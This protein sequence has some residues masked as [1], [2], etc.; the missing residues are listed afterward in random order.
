[1]KFSSTV[2]STLALLSFGTSTTTNAADVNQGALDAAISC[3][4]EFGPLTFVLLEDEAVNAA[5]E[6]DIRQDLA[7]IGF[8]VEARPLSKAD[9]NVAKQSGNFHFSISETWGTPYDPSSYASGWIDGDGGAGVFPSMVNMEAPS[10]REE[11][12]DMVK[13][14]L[15]EDRPSELETKWEAIHKYYHEQAIMM[16][17]YGK[18]IPT[19]YNRRL[20][21]YEAGYQQFDYPVHR[22]SPV[23]GSTTVTIAPGARTGL[24]KTVGTLNAHVYGPNEFFSNN[25]I[26]EGLVSYGANGQILPSL[27]TKWVVT[28]NNIG[29]DDYTFTLRDGVTFH[30]GAAWN[31]TVAK[32]NF[33][34]IFA[35][36]L[37]TEKHGWYGVG[38]YTEEAVCNSDM[39]LV[40][41]TNS[42][43]GPYLQELTLI[44][45]TRMI[46]PNAF[47]DG[48]STDP[49]S[50]NS[51]HLDW[52]TVDATEFKEEVTC[53]GI[54]S[55]SG[56]GPFKFVSRET[57]DGIDTRV[58]FEANEDYWGGAPA[59]KRLEVVRYATSAEV[60]DALLNGEL[61]LVWGGGVLSDA[62]IVEIQNDPTLSER[63]QVAHSGDLQN[64]ILLLNSGNPP[65]DDI[66]VR[67]T[68][69]HSINKAAIVESELSGL[70]QVVDSIFPLEAPYCDVDL[71]PRWDYDFEKAVL[72]SCDGTA[73]N[74]VSNENEDKC[75]GLAVGLGIGLGVIAALALV[76]GINMY[77]KNKKLQ[78]E[79][80]L[81]RKEGAVDA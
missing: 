3:N 35:G 47:V 7:K 77:C 62:D 38:L 76:C 53:V 67:K 22:M 21:G 43:H 55:I 54:Q 16:P 32:Q 65:F 45:P 69:I 73:G 56:T 19:L 9:I 52:G 58:I 36:A 37:S 14:V 5:I 30:D 42:K 17:L 15:K 46:S 61:D 41:R 34:H 51:C 18:R 29:G 72:L 33:D 75:N 74:F 12:L 49:L 23:S 8:E 6:D 48:S 27:A 68:V 26:Y 25:W 59:I 28:S 24:F 40:L 1:M 63:I 64:V 66:N 57:G 50:A 80:N 71:T 2:V 13:D 20:T 11:L 44:R 70:Q 31:C 10:T 39:E 81:Q 78:E 79:L 4:K 60:K